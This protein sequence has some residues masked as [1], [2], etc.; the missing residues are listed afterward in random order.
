MSRRRSYRSEVRDAGARET[1]LRVRD[2]ARRLFVTR[3]FAET[4][5]AQIADDAGVSPQTIY[6]VFGSKGGIV[7]AMLEDLE[8]SA[9]HDS[10]VAEIMAEDDP[11]QQLRLFVAM[12]RTM[13]ERG[14]PILRAMISALGERSA[15]RENAVARLQ[16]LIDEFTEQRVDEATITELKS[17]LDE[18]SS[19]R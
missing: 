10:R 1:R 13:F 8:E 6:A 2:S 11:R 15:A 4:T 5:I 18:F 17:V 9:D 19:N 12:N 16:I 3:G 14:A 7:G